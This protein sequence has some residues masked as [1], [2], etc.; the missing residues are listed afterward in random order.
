MA[1]A[2][3]YSWAGF[4]YDNL[5][6][7][8]DDEGINYELGYYIG[9]WS[10]VSVDGSLRSDVSVSAGDVSYRFCQQSLYW[11]GKG[12]NFPAIPSWQKEGEEWMSNEQKL[13]TSLYGWSSFVLV[14]CTLL[15]ITSISVRTFIYRANYEACGKDQGIP[16]SDVA[17][18]SSYIPEVRSGIF[19]YPLL[20]VDTDHVD[21]E[22]YEWKD[23]DK[24][25]SYYDLTRDA[26][27]ILKDVRS[28]V[29]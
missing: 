23:P 14:L 27:Q 11:Y 20:A 6:I 26:R 13:L 3:S 19:S 10:V 16:F 1:V 15:W 4:P 5:C 24:P 25:H 22:L 2:C 18:I 28:E 17:A 21:E 8:N 12:F 9:N 29:A 7:N